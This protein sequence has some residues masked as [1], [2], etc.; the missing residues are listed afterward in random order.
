MVHLPSLGEGK[1]QGEDEFEGVVERKP[2]YSANG[3]LKDPEY[4]D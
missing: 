2:V 3:A 4:V 1:P